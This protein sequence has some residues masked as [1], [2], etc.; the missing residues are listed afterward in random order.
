MSLN[1]EDIILTIFYG[2]VVILG[3]IRNALVVKWF[4][5]REEAGSKLVVVL[6]IN[7]F[8]ASLLVPLN[9][10]H[11]AVRHSLEPSD[12]WYLGQC[13]CYILHGMQM[14]FLYTTSWILIAI[15]IERFR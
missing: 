15:A 10:I 6:A 2:F 1:S 5:A 14:T 4:W 8:L 9:K 13:L 11:G 3:T 12:A 7:D